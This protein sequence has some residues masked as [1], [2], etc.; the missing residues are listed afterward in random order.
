MEKKSN[1]AYKWRKIF[2]AK[3][4]T[5]GKIELEPGDAQE[6]IDDIERAFGAE[7]MQREVATK[8]I[9]K[10]DFKTASLTDIT[11]LIRNGSES[12]A[13]FV[14]GA[15]MGRIV[16]EMQ[17]EGVTKITKEEIK[18]REGMKV[19]RVFWFSSL[20]SNFGLVLCNNGHTNKAYIDTIVGKSE[21]TDVD[22]ILKNGAK[23]GYEHGIAIM[24]HL[25]SKRNEEAGLL[26][27][28]MSEED[29]EFLQ[30]FLKKQG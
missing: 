13:H 26:S 21:K 1:V 18:E 11:R 16:A 17:K 30:N 12:F 20:S 4:C 19:D 10:A 28:P 24:L 25:R 29:R 6:L 2:A 15:F 9:D 14:M 3:N 8:M 5:E 7:Q 27:E 23:I 22:M